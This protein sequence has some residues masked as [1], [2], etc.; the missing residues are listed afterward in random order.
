MAINLI[1]ASKILGKTIV[2]N[3][4][5]TPD[6]RNDTGIQVPA[7][8]LIANRTTFE[9]DF[10]A[11]QSALP[12]Y[13]QIITGTSVN[14]TLK[15]NTFSVFSRPFPDLGLTLGG[16]DLAVQCMFNDIPLQWNDTYDSAYSNRDMQTQPADLVQRVLSLTKANFVNKN[17]PLYLN[18]SDKLGLQIVGRVA[19]NQSIYFSYVVSYEEVS[20][21]A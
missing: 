8:R 19:P 12:Y 3:F 13:K 14:T 9:D 4:V 18:Q 16:V 6:G 5:I 1:A 10:P 2:G 17:E 21:T 20:L 15:I 11:Q 7:D